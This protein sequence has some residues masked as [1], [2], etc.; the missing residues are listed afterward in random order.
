MYRTDL[1]R[2]QS[3]VAAC[4]VIL[5]ALPLSP[6][7]AQGAL[8]SV[9]ADVGA[10]NDSVRVDADVTLGGSD[11]TLA[12]V[13]ADVGIG[14]SGASSG[15]ANSASGSGGGTIAASAGAC[16]GS[17]NS[18]SG[19]GGTGSGSGGAGSGGN[20]SG[21]NGSGGGGA[22]ASADGTARPE[23]DRR[24]PRAAAAKDLG[25]LLGRAV[26][27]ADLRPLGVV[28]GVQRVDRGIALSV[29]LLDG[30]GAAAASA[31]IIL[32]RVPA[33]DSVKLSMSYDSFVARL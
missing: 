32:A 8:G 17:C 1:T 3:H 26:L 12:G 29:R 7:Q 13:D 28:E 14:G 6:L 30:L 23:D 25:H 16:V 10:L 4:A 33:G 20:G 2:F 11:G 31:T 19:G 22:V 5:A 24:T 9:S 18:V 27:S 21:G 15:G